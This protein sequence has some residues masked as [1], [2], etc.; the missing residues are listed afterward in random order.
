MCQEAEQH[1][2]KAK[3]LRQ[4]AAVLRQKAAAVCQ[5]AED[6]WK[7]TWKR[8]QQQTVLE[9]QQGPEEVTATAPIC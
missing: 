3:Q 5:A 6:T 9:Q 1:R 4:A 8:V 7:I 2:Q